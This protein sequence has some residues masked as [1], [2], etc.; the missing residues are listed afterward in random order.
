ML[1]TIKGI[2]E[3]GQIILSEDA[4]LKNKSKVLIT[5]IDELDSTSKFQKR[6]LG[7]LNG[8]Y[9]LPENFNETLEEL[10]EC[11]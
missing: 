8:K 11:F 10:K 4:P 9:K 1:T 3:N 6:K 2:Y 7:L 5:F